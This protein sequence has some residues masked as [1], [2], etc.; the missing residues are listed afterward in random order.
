MKCSDNVVRL[1]LTKKHR[2]VSEVDRCRLVDLEPVAPEK[3]NLVSHYRSA[4]PLLNFCRADLSPGEETVLG[5]HA[6]V[7][8]LGGEGRVNGQVVR[9]GS[10]LLVG[11]E[12]RLSSVSFVGAYQKI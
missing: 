2:A 4:M 12:D 1:G 9:A 7:V 5:E 11:P 6:L 10:C 3:F 8:V